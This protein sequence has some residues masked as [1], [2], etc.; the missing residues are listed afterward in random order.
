ME[1]SIPFRNLQLHSRFFYLP[2]LCLSVPSDYTYLCIPGIDFALFL[3]RLLNP[4]PSS[5]GWGCGREGRENKQSLIQ[6]W[7][8]VQSTWPG[9]FLSVPICSHVSWSS[10]SLEVTYSPSVFFQGPLA[11]PT[12]FLHFPNPPLLLL[13]WTMQGGSEAKKV[14][15]SRTC[16]LFSWSL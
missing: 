9:H 5:R 14:L 10:A 15:W 6:V 12:K 1:K 4:L 2:M 7:V 16:N 11:T 3:F 8:N 13:R